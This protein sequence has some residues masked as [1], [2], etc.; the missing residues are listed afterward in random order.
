MFNQKHK[1]FKYLFFGVFFLCAV[2]I[3]FGAVPPPPPP[4]GCWP[5]PCIPIDGG[6]S[7]LIAAGALYG[8]KKSYDKF[9]SRRDKGQT[10]YSE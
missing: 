8:V 9:K 4:P 10:G 7:L 2:S 5:P 6:V 3:V 1:Y